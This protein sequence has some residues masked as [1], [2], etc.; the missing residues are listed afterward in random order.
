MKCPCCSNKKFNECCGKIIQSK[1]AQSPEQLMRSRFSAYAT[2]NAKYIYN[3]YAEKTRCNLTL[4]DLQKEMNNC[5]WTKLVINSC[6]PFEKNKPTLD[7]KK[8]PT[9]SFSAYYILNNQLVKMSETS[10]FIYS[11]KWYY[12]DGDNIEHNELGRIKSNDIC[13]CFGNSLAGGLVNT[14]KAKKF[15]HCCAR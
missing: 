10:R 15:K 8:A 12:L 9:V 13:P 11:D 1:N 7:L 3:S 4:D 5:I 2:K 6:S 14:K